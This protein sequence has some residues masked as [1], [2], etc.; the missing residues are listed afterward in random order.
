MSYYK[1]NVNEFKFQKNTLFVKVNLKKA[2]KASIIERWREFLF[3][4]TNV[5]MLLFKKLFE[6]KGEENHVQRH[7]KLRIQTGIK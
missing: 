6:R 5:K 2:E 7:G 1:E 3:K 4:K